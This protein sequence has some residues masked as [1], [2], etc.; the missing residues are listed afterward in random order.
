M[1]NEQ[2][3][4]RVELDN[5]VDAVFLGRLAS[6][7]SGVFYDMRFTH[8]ETMESVE[9]PMH[10]MEHGQQIMDLLRKGNS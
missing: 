7:G 5:D 8:T 6:D 9:F 1:A 10:N 2:V 3:I 4:D